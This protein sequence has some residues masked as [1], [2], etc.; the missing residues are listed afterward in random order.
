MQKSLITRKNHGYLSGSGRKSDKRAS[1]QR[2]NEYTTWLGGGSGY[3]KY[4]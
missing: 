3:V 1:C 4:S 2:F